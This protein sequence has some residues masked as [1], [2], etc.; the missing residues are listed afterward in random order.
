MIA[1]KM[2]F[3]IAKAKL[4]FLIE[5]GLLKLVEIGLDPLTPLELTV[6]K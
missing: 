6:R 3:M 4:A 2:Q 5:Q 1:K